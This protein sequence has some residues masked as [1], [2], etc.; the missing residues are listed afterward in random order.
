MKKEDINSELISKIEIQIQD[1]LF[2]MPGETVKGNI[3]I[4]PKYQM[5]I[6]DKTLHLNLKIMQYE[7]WE[8]LNVEIKEFNNIYTTNIQEKDFEYKLNDEIKETKEEI[9]DDFSII[10]K[11]EEDKIISIPFEIK[12]DDKKILP[13]FQYE[14][15]DYFLGI[16]HLL[17]VECKEY[18]SSNYIGLFIGKSKNNEYSEPKEIKETYIVGLGTLDI[19]ASYPKLSYSSG[20]KINIGIE[21]NSNLH[22]KK[23]TQLQQ[24]F[25]RDIE[26]VGNFKNTLL[27]NHIFDTQTFKYNENNKA[28][29]SQI[30]DLPL[31]PI[32]SMVRGAIRGPLLG[33]FCGYTGFT[34]IGAFLNMLSAEPKEYNNSIVGGIIGGLIGAPVGIVGGFCSGMIENGLVMKDV[35][36]LNDNIGSMYNNFGAQIKNPEYKKW[37]VKNLEKFVYFKDDKVIGFIKFAQNITPPVNG[38]YFNCNY[39][40][41]IEVQIEGVI[42]NRN[43]YIKT[44]IDIYDSDEYIANMKNIFRNKI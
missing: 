41:N 31:N 8:Y 17:L 34:P 32:C 6:K 18:M 39:N 42:L 3:I 16:R 43:R 11:E 37:F 20:E 36:N 1:T 28:G 7:F 35:L 33:M 4:N 44:E 2:Y 24:V 19:I 26:W 14:D 13:T 5:K 22:F 38:Y 40:I 21:T 12:I 27:D 15:K 25:Y 10:E 23:I 9:F 29:L 30:I